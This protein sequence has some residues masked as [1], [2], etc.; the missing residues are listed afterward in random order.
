MAGRPTECMTGSRCHSC[1]WGHQVLPQDIRDPLVNHPARAS[2]L[3]VCIESMRL[4]YNASL[5]QHIFSLP[6]LDLTYD[7]EAHPHSM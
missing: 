1:F 2:L 7:V 6:D 3:E 5:R 4:P